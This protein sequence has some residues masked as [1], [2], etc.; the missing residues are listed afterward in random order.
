MTTI[1]PS[2][3]NTAWFEAKKHEAEVTPKRGRKRAPVDK[4]RRDSAQHVLLVAHERL[5]TWEQ[6]AS[7]FKL[8]KA[9]VYRI[10]NDNSYRPS[11]AMLNAIIETGLPMV[12]HIPVPPCPD[13]GSIHTGRCNNRPVAQVVTL[14][15]G[16]VIKPAPK[17]RKREAYWRPCLPLG[18]RQRCQDAGIDIHQVIEEALK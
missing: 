5:R 17:Q 16:E 1:A 6:V 7:F 12:R 2:D 8:S 15:P 14:A 9:S 18:L 4:E 3:Q 11:R 13:C 10:A